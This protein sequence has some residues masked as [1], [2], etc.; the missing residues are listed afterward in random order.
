METNVMHY[1]GYSELYLNDK[2]VKLTPSFDQGTANK[3]RF[4]PMAELYLFYHTNP[5]SKKLSDHHS[6]N[7][8][9]LE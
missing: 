3:G 5:T 1:H 6:Q 4:L 2:W 9:L 8:K 7:N